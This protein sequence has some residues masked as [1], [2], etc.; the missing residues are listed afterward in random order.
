MGKNKILIRVEIKEIIIN[1]QEISVKNI[2]AE[3]VVE[4]TKNN[5]KSKKQWKEA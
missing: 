1:P 5:I 2:L 3:F 4:C